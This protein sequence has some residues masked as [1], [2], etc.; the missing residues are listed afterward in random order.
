M[1]LSNY[2]LKQFEKY[3]GEKLLY[4]PL[5]AYFEKNM[6]SRKYV[7][8]CE[9]N[10]WEFFVDHLTIRTYKID[11]A[12]KKYEKLGWKYET[13]IEYLNEGW[14]AKVYRHSEY[15]PMFI[16]Q[17]Y[18][19]APS[20]KQLLRKWVDKFG[21]KDFHHLAFR[22][23]QGVEIEE[24][25]DFLQKKGVNLPGRITGPKGSRLR[26][27]FTQA[28]VVDEVP[29]SVVELAQRSKDP[30]TGKVY[31]GFISEQADSLMK[32]SVL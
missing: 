4:E 5:T 6:A 30:K 13:T 22:L 17:T 25:I 18:D 20:D 23:P 1:A 12:A 28:E 7:E 19:N 14:W 8:V 31:E 2:L 3:K 15:A 11:E 29:F 10:N 16:D 9:E 27:I 32:D 24:A 21:D 26:Q